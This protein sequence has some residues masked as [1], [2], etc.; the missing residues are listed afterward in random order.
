M[1]NITEKK[2]KKKFKLKLSLKII[3]INFVTTLIVNT[4]LFFLLLIVR[5]STNLSLDTDTAERWLSLL[6]FI[7]GIISIVLFAVAINIFIVKRIKQLNDS[8][9]EVAS[10][11][12]NVQLQEKGKD[13]LAELATSFNIMANELKAN[14]YLAKE[15]VRNI[16]HEYKTPLSVIKAYAEWIGSELGE[17]IVD[18]KQL[19][20]YA[21]II[22][23]EADRMAALSK[24]M[25]ELSLLEST[26]IIKKEDTFCPAAQIN[27]ILKTMQV[28]WG[29]K[30]LEFDLQLN[31]TAI[32]SNEQLLYQVWQNLISNAVKFTDSGGK[33]KMLLQ[34]T[35]K[36][37]HFEI[38]DSGI[39]L[40]EQD[41]EKLFTLFFMA[42]K[43]RNT[44]GS[45]LGLAITQR[46]I[47]KLGGSIAVKSEENKGT[48]F[49]VKLDK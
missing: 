37:L 44:E 45:G 16:S 8:T 47:N 21:D 19:Q 4:A 28:K 1:N 24:S 3:L 2:S 22:I 13:E 26:T 36:E 46:I 17:K 41:K 12:F 33:I 6:S 7:T 27:N 42:D 25:I 15:F 32:T 20:E 34:I 38:T 14:E 43:S 23:N 39:G 11:N 5:T 29:Q 40:N 49:V 31:D 9:K 18:K 30:Q 48:T 35:D 10:G